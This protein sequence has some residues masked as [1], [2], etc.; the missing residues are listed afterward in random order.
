MD[1]GNRK[2]R[3]IHLPGHTPGSIAVLDI[4]RRVMISGDPLQAH[5]HIFM[6]GE[7]RNMKDYILSLQ[8]LD[9][10]KDSFDE[11][12]PSH[13]D[14]PVYPDCIRK[15]HDGAQRILNGEAEGHETEF[16][17]QRIMVYDLGFTTF[18]CNK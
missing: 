10:V 5:G 12:W 8:K 3:I 1:L 15:L 6:F 18:L 11:I 9:Q 16:F 2:L 7:H 4:S 17:G 14:I 13:A